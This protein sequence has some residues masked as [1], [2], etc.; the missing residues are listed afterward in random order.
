[1]PSRRLEL[2]AVPHSRNNIFGLPGKVQVP[3][4]PYPLILLFILPHL[5]D[6]E[7]LIHTLAEYPTIADKPIR[8]TKLLKIF[9]SRACRTSVMIG[10]ALGM[11]KMQKV[12]NKVSKLNISPL[13]NS[14]FLIF[15]L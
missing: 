1:M 9:A 12:N 15:R 10:D 14:F 8:C 13:L 4:F 7:E 5:S 11:G 2:H 3:T 6:L